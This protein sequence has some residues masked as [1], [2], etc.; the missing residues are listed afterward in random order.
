MSLKVLYCMKNVKSIKK[1][2]F[3]YGE[4][5]NNDD[6]T[7]SRRVYD[8]SIGIRTTQ[9]CMQAYGPAVSTVQIQTIS[10]CL[11]GEPSWVNS[12]LASLDRL[13]DP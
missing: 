7:A 1:C 11:Q 10:M 4:D 13:E 9:S 2:V 8:G 6:S 3:E 5:D 12:T